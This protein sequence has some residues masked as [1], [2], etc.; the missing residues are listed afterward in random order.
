MIATTKRLNSAMTT[1]I[2]TSVNPAARARDRLSGSFMGSWAAD[3]SLVIRGAIGNH[4]VGEYLA[5]AREN[6]DALGLHLAQL[7][8]ER[9]LFQRNVIGDIIR[10]ARHRN[11]HDVGLGGKIS[12]CA[13]N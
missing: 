6:P 10:S 8:R 9:D 12:N 1:Y 5:G 3:G 11:I 13:N 7:R 4:G 2:S